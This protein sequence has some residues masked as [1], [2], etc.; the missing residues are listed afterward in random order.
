MEGKK[1][2]GMFVTKKKE[3]ESG[4]IASPTVQTLV[5]ED[6]NAAATPSSRS[7]YPPFPE[8]RGARS[9]RPAAGPTSTLNSHMSFEGD[10]KYQGTV[11]I[12]C[13]F[14]GKVSTEDALVIGPGARVQAELTAGTVE[15]SGKVQGDIHARQSVRILSGGEVYGNIETPTI[16]M[17]EG[18]VFEGNC[19]RPPG[20]PKPAAL[21][22]RA[23]TAGA[24]PTAPAPTKPAASVAPGGGSAPKAADPVSSPT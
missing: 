9:P 5:Q 4:D 1:G 2:M 17:A 10:L 6:P 20:S 19:T 16:S 8:S 7:L 14:R 13:E 24:R 12:D 18:V 22:G 15:I 3:V 11:V 23:P 21:T